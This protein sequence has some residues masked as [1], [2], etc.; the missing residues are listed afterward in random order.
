MRTLVIGDIHGC[1]DE[2]KALLEAVSY[3][4]RVDTLVFVGDLIDRGPDPVGVVRFIRSLQSAGNVLVCMGNHDEKAAKYLLRLEQ[5]RTQGIPNKMGP[6][7]P[8]RLVEW[9]SFTPEELDWIKGLPTV[10]EPIP[11]WIAVHAGFEGDK[12]RDKQKP[13]KVVRVRWV[14]ADTGKMVGFEGNNLDQP[15]GT[16]HWSSFWRG[17]E[18]V[19]YGHAVHSLKNPRVDR[20]VEGVECWGIDTGACYGGRL[21]ALCLETREV[22]QVQAERAYAKLRRPVLR[23]G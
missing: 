11:G 17:P 1:L 12:T 4:P 20:P 9:Q 10:I 22:T 19:V 2:L 16:V 13:D 8:E 14:N 15:E 6:P 21:T 18:N 3:V 23:D 7:T 5:E